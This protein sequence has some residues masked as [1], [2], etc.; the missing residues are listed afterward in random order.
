MR[1]QSQTATSRPFSPLQRGDSFV[2][3]NCSRRCTCARSGM[4][5]GEP[6]SCRA[7]EICTLGNLTRGCFRSEPR[8]PRGFKLSPYLGGG[9][10]A[11]GHPSRSCVLWLR[12]S[13]SMSGSWALNPTLSS[14][15]GRGRGSEQ[16]LSSRHSAGAFS[17]H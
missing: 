16:L 4:L 2:T 9:C 11:D 17:W 1:E 10:W 7:G 15:L 3:E 12:P 6:L 5:L 8:R 13:P 14:F